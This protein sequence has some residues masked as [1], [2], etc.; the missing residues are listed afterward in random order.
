MKSFYTVVASAALANL[1]YS[2][3]TFSPP[4]PEDCMAL[5]LA[6]SGFISE[7]A[8]EEAPHFAINEFGLLAQ[9]L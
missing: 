3:V 4:L 8:C 7:D 6:T 5:E 1:A 2:Q 9:G